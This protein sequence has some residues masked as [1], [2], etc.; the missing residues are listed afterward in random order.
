MRIPSYAS[1]LFVA[2]LLGS[3]LV[4][5]ATG[6]AQRRASAPVEGAVEVH[7]SIGLSRGA[8]AGLGVDLRGTYWAAH[9]RGYRAGPDF[10]LGWAGFP[11]DHRGS[12]RVVRLAGGARIAFPSGTVTPA[13]Y[14]RVG[15]HSL[16]G[17]WLGR[18]FW[19]GSR[20]G[21]LGL[22]GG[23]ALDVAVAHNVSL[24]GHG[25]LNLLVNGFAYF[26]L[27][28]HFAVRL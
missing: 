27:G 1:L 9:E 5:P 17:P 24:G 21:H 26:N 23:G 16:G 4:L 18:W 19:H 28:V 6:W 25:G 7:P 10:V 20:L 22:E 8:G 3:A 15:L 12:A 13:V 2:F 11:L 14:G